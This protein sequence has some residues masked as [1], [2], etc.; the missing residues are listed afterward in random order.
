MSLTAIQDVQNTK[1]R[2][3]TFDAALTLTTNNLANYSTK[4]RVA[5]G[6]LKTKASVLLK[7]FFY[8]CLIFPK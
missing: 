4:R 3:T 5:K 7:M 2:K 6:K 1:F 8:W